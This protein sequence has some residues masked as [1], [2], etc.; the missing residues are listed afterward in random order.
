VSNAS[1]TYGVK[2]REGQ[3]HYE[4]SRKDALRSQKE[5][6]GLAVRNKNG[7]VKPF[8]R[9]KTFLWFFLA[10]QLIMLIWIISAANTGNG[11]TPAEI[12]QLCGNNAWSPLFSSYNDCVVNGAHGIQD[13]HSVGTGLAVGVLVIGWVIVDFLVG[14]TYGI[15]RLVTR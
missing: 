12:A 7:T 4:N 13:A 9:R 10:L 15:Y 2:N 14:V 8:K 1:S 3:I 11:A 5:F 6:G